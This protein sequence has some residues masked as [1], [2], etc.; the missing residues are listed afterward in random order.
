MRLSKRRRALW[1]AAGCAAILPRAALAGYSILD[2]GTLGGVESQALGLNDKGQVVGYAFTGTGAKRAFR[3]FPNAAINSTTDNLGVLSGGS[4]SVAF[5]VNFSGQV[6]GHS[7]SSGG[8]RAFRYSGSTMT[9]LG[10]L[11]GNNWSYAR[12]INNAGYVAG[13]SS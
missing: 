8:D 4:V 10:V 5:S 9:S 11:N 12:G 1:L 13:S 7:S 6:A 3:T 2:L